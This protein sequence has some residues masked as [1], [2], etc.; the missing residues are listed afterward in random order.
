MLKS[1]GRCC[2]LN[3]TTSAG[4]S[5]S[6]YTSS[7][8][9]FFIF[10]EL[11]WKP[12][13]HG[14][15]EVHITKNK[16]NSRWGAERFGDCLHS[17]VKSFVAPVRGPLVISYISSKLSAVLKCRSIDLCHVW[18]KKTNRM[19]D[20]RTDWCCAA[21][22]QSCVAIQI[23]GPLWRRA[24]WEHDRNCLLWVCGALDRSPTWS[25]RECGWGGDQWK[26]M[27]GRKK[28]KCQCLLAVLES[29]VTTARKAF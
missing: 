3:V 17:S 8:V 7:A 20:W 28:K 11:Y 27:T 12:R 6:T 19:G 2:T 29:E 9:L 5:I 4:F 13:K 26:T 16:T 10:T 14:A 1:S 15:S 18:G 24:K 22:W 21:W 23:A 25:E